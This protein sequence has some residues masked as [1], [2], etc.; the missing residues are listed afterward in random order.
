V[1][2]ELIVLVKYL[3]LPALFYFIGSGNLCVPRVSN[4]LFYN[5]PC[6]L[7]LG[8]HSLYYVLVNAAN[9]ILRH[10]SSQIGL[11]KESLRLS[12]IDSFY[13]LEQDS[14]PPGWRALTALFQYSMR[15]SVTVVE[16]H[17]VIYD[18]QPLSLPD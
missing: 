6:G 1:L 9:F 18:V 15:A 8:G 10:D 12:Q 3:P 16:I 14:E 13:V 4:I 2:K 11:N 7:P 5:M 17:E